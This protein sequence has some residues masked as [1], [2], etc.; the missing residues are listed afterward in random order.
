LDFERVAA[1]AALPTRRDEA[2]ATIASICRSYGL[3]AAADAVASRSSL[4]TSA[5][6]RILERGLPVDRHSFE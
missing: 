1:L 2:A 5:A 4:G 3:D 6:R